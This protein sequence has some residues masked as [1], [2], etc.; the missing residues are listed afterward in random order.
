MLDETKSIRLRQSN[1]ISK[2]INIFVSSAPKSTVICS[3]KASN[4]LDKHG[5]NLFAKRRTIIISTDSLE[6]WF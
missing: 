3:L 6:V 5:T 2:A 1:E 4:V